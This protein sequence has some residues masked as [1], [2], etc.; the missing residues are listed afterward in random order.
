MDRSYAQSTRNSKL[1][2][3]PNVATERQT[4]KDMK[5]REQ[6]APLKR[7]LPRLIAAVSLFLVALTAACIKIEV[8]TNSS[9]VGGF[10]PPAPVY[11]PPPTGGGGSGPIVT[12]PPHGDSVVFYPSNIWP[13]QDLDS[14]CFSKNGGWKGYF[15]FTNRFEGPHSIHSTNV[16]NVYRNDDDLTNL[17]IKTCNVLNYT[18]VVTGIVLLEGMD[19][20][21]CASNNCFISPSLTR[22]AKE[23]TVNTQYIGRIYLKETNLIT[24]LIVDWNYQ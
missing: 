12:P 21:D 15:E 2:L 11:P 17:V 14:D 4:I 6:S 13:N 24:S 1:A 22:L 19:K 9:A 18:N 10:G 16:A 5:T 8:N 7:V 23:M 20:R 3:R